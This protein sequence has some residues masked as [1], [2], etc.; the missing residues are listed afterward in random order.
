M[1]DQQRPAARPDAPTNG[2]TNGTRARGPGPEISRKVLVRLLDPRGGDSVH[3]LT[4]LLHRAYKRHADR[5]MRAIAAFQDDMTTVKRITGGECYVAV[6]RDDER[7]IVGTIVFKDAD[8]TKGTPWFDRAGVAS[9]SQ[10]AV[11]P[12]LQGRGIGGMLIRKAESRA[13]ETGSVEIALSTPEPASELLAMYAHKGYRTVDHMNWPGTN[14]RSVIMSK[15]VP[16]GA[17]AASAS[18]VVHGAG[19]SA[20]NTPIKPSFH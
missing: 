9:F 14:Y 8:H 11:E 3:E 20:P 5:G 18:V 1:E 2:A 15:A 19:A 12:W 16:K 13:L 7:R 10:L 6:L 17:D 4:E